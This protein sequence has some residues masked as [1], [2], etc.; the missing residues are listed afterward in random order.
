MHLKKGELYRTWAYCLFVYSHVPSYLTIRTS[1]VRF[2]AELRRPINNTN[3]NWAIHRV[4][5]AEAK[6]FAIQNDE[7]IAHATYL[8]K[9]Q[10]RSERLLF[11]EPK[12]L[13][14]IKRFKPGALL[15]AT[16]DAS[17]ELWVK[18]VIEDT[19]GFIVNRDWLELERVL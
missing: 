2:S 18:V 7:S 16:E 13:P 12:S 17:E 19:V 6:T 11:G 1:P 14:D 9:S 5:N 15:L 8:L 4:I 10:Y 3:E